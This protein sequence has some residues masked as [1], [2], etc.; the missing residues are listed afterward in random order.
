MT[1]QDPL[2]PP[3][4]PERELELG[5]EPDLGSSPQEITS[6]DVEGYMEAAAVAGPMRKAAQAG[7]WESYDLGLRQQHQQAALATG[8]VLMEGGNPALETRPI[9]SMVAP[10]IEI[11]RRMTAIWEQEEQVAEVLEAGGFGGIKD[12]LQGVAQQYREQNDA[13]LDSNDP[14]QLSPVTV[15]PNMVADLRQQAVKLDQEMKAINPEMSFWTHPRT[16]KFAE[17]LNREAGA[18]G[19]GYL[20]SGEQE[21]E[22]GVAGKVAMAGVEMIEGAQDVGL[23]IIYGTWELADRGVRAVGGP[24]LGAPPSNY[25]EDADGHVI[26]N[27]GKVP[28]FMEATMALWAHATDQNVESAIAR[29]NRARELEVANRNGFENVVYGASHVVGMGFGFGL[30]AGAAMHAGA[31]VGTQ[32]TTKGLAYLGSL[33]IKGP[34]SARALKITKLLGGGLGATAAN[35]ALEGIAFGRHEGYGTAFLHGAAM[36]PALMALGSMGRRTEWFLRNRA[37]MPKR[38]AAGISGAVEGMGFGTMEVMQTG[39]L[40]DFLKNPDETTFQTY[41]KNMLGFMLFKAWGAVPT[42]GEGALDALTTQVHRG[43]ARQEFAEKVARGEALEADIARS[44]MDEASLRE[45][46]ELSIRIKEAKSPEEAARLHEQLRDLEVQMDVTELGLEGPAE[47]ELARAREPEGPL[48][49]PQRR[50]TTLKEIAERSQEPPQQ[51]PRPQREAGEALMRAWEGK[52]SRPEPSEGKSPLDKAVRKLQLEDQVPRAKKGRAK[53]R[54]VLDEVVQKMQE[55]P[56]QG[57]R[58]RREVDEALG[59]AWTGEGNRESLEARSPLDKAVQ[60]ERYM[61]DLAR[62]RAPLAERPLDTTLREPEVLRE[63]EAPYE[64]GA[65]I[66]RQGVKGERAGPGSLQVPPTRQVEPTEGVGAVS[67]AD[68]YRAFEGAPGRKGVRIP[69]TSVRI[70]GRKA[71]AVRVPMREGKIPGKNT[72]GLFKLF[73]NLVRTKD[74]RDLVVGSH[75]WSHAMHRHVSEQSG[76]GFHKAAKEQYQEALKRDRRI[77]EDVDAILR[78]YPGSENLTKAVRW[79]E[80]WAEW[81]ARNLLGEVGLDAKFPAVSKYMREMLAHPSNAGIRKQYQHIQEL[82]YSYNAQGS[83]ARVEKTVKFDLDKLSSEQKR[84]EPSRLQRLTDEVNRLM[85][86]DMAGLKRSQEKWMEAVGG[87]MERVSILDDPARLHDTLRMTGPKTAEQYIMR[88]VRTPEGDFVPGLVPI[89]KKVK[90]LS[91]EFTT[92]VVAVRNIELYNK[93]KKVQLPPN[94]YIE[95]AKQLSAKHPEFIE[96]AR[97]LKRWTDAIVDFVARSGNLDE[98]SAQAIKDAYVLYVPFFR[99]IEGPRAHGQGR[100]VAE[101]GSGLG[102]IKGSTYEIRDPLVAIQ[103]VV[104]SMISKAHQNMVVGALYR[105]ASAH[106]LGGLATIVPKSSVPKD[107]HLLRVMDAVA[108]QARI[109]E[110]VQPEFESLVDAL[111]QADVLN[112]QTITL[113]TQKVIPTGERSIIAYTPRMTAEDIARVARDPA[114]K[115]ILESNNNKLQWLEIDNKAYEAVMGIDKIPSMSD[116]IDNPIARAVV[117]GPAKV[118]RFFATG[119]APGFAVANVVR[120]MMSQP[121]FSKEGNFLP[122]AGIIKWFQ[123]AAIYAER[124]QMREL[125]DELG[126]RTSSFLDAGAR[127]RIAGHD[128]SL[129]QKAGE[130]VRKT[131]EVLAAP[132][133]FLRIKEFADTYKRAQAEGKSELEARMLALEAGREITV[134]FA[135]AGVISRLANQV[136]PYFN[137]TVQGQRKLWRQVIGGGDAKSDAAKAKVQRA[138]ILNGI[139][140]ITV[141]SLLLAYMNRDEEWYQDLPEW[142]KLHYWNINVGGEQ[143]L[144]IPKPFEAGVVFGS[145]PEMWLDRNPVGADEAL[146]NAFLGY[147]DGPAAI[148]SATLLPSIE[149]AANYNFFTGRPI[150]P[151]WIQRTRKP[152]DQATLYTTEVAKSLSQAINGVLTPTEIEHWLAGHT[153][154]ASTAAMRTIDDIMGLSNHANIWKEASPVSRFIRQ[155]EHG[156]SRAVDQLYD[157]STR[158][159]QEHGSGSISPER[160]RLRRQV[161]A[162]KRQLS[163]IRRSF[164]QGTITREQA[165]RR[166]FEVAE[167][168]TRED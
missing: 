69:L 133:N 90:G 52:S 152:E 119:L 102:R 116:V 124:G 76:V 43:R 147:L 167:P 100:G 93:G 109:P 77:E 120:D 20:Q 19:V 113:F 30:P 123:G 121:L 141:P 98:A 148:L 81:N 37:K 14:M 10:D 135:R 22:M 33:G 57:P 146:K 143:I 75:E 161:D 92:Y 15:D 44:P 128:R 110:H 66:G 5:P 137:P 125:Y 31:K 118:V 48:Q 39:A 72:L 78:D 158:L 105:M 56:Q 28:G 168:L 156:H 53:P 40:W 2:R 51:G 107:H 139:T 6:S 50:R 4:P 83:V 86:D 157:L 97:G 80:T 7:D 13:A 74:G 35:G 94:D 42:P 127:R 41:A 24:G 79:M 61:A 153:A 16:R 89:M 54:S 111:R 166:S 132:E 159:D 67:A 59:K 154:G 12:F 25:T 49:G 122:G 126:V 138:A 84:T 140:N 82:L 64:V 104:S 117:T 149:V 155:E 11:R 23:N 130:W 103:E 45:L 134:N 62:G 63:P 129:M 145:I 160:G 26:H 131:Q 3:P 142:R 38:L 34:Q 101:K 70:G 32:M 108:Q 8:Q 65:Q 27:G 144:S 99:A 29:L 163:N 95:A 136:V 46:G 55:P 1:D 112:P 150:T 164:R 9:G 87:N 58:P 151:E 114:H 68:I 85:F 47:R 36:T 71:D 17:W 106:E 96:T 162:A 165:N 73:E 91:R 60:R 21:L 88:G 18:G 115:K